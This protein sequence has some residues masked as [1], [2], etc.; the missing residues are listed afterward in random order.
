MP[1]PPTAELESLLADD[2]WI[3]RLARR[4]TADPSTA[5][6]LAQD[7][8]LAVLSGRAP[9]VAGTERPWLGRVLRN[10]WKDL[11]R[12]RGRRERRERSAAREEATPPADELVLELEL[13]ERLARALRELEE[14]YRRALVLRFLRDE[15]LA[16]IAKQEHVAV[17][18]IH[19][20]IERGLARL[21]ARLDDEHGGHRAAWAATLITLAPEASAGG[22]PFEVMALATVVKI[23]AAV[24]VLGTGAAWWW[25]RQGREVVRVSEAVVA[26]QAAAEAEHEDLRAL[27]PAPAAR[28]ALAPQV[29]SVPTPIVAGDEA[30]MISGRVLDPHG[31]GVSGALLGWRKPRD[32]DEPAVSAAD[33]AFELAG[34]TLEANGNVVVRSPEL[35]TL[36][37]GQLFGNWTLVAAPRAAFGGTVVDDSGAPIAGAELEF[38][39]K[40]TLF[41]AVGMHALGLEDERWSTTSDALGRFE[42]RDV[43]GGENV[44]LRAR[45]RGFVPVEVPLPEG[46]DPALLVT[47]QRKQATVELG[48]IVLDPAG[49]PVPGASVSAGKEIVTTG[50]DGRFTLL[51]DGGN[52]RSVQDE[53]GT[54]HEE[55]AERAQVIAL[56]AGYR[57]DQEALRERDL[58]LPFVLQL[59]A[60]LSITGFALDPEG[61]PLSGIVVWLQDPTRF[62]RER[63]TAGGAEFDR[64]LTVEDLVCARAEPAALTVPDGSF[65]IACLMDR[66]YSVLALDP[67]TCSRS[68][69]WSI[70]AGTQDVELVFTPEPTERVAGRIVSARGKPRAGLEVTPRRTRSW[71]AG[72]EAPELSGARIRVE[73]DAEGRFEFAQLATTG[74]A[75]QIAAQP[76]SMRVLELDGFTDLAR[77]E[78]VEPELCELQ[79]ELAGDPHSAT[80][81]EVLDGSG[82]ELELHEVHGG[83]NSFAYSLETE[84][85]LVEG[86]SRLLFVQETAS[87]LVLRKAGQEVLRVPLQLEPGRRVVKRL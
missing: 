82:T 86:R 42:L 54:W 87:E 24:L 33:G 17:S 13:R 60:P 32:G 40:E 27:A 20:R 50:A 30:A 6:D 51:W 47:L 8:W 1:V 74:T 65:E 10:T 84:V 73:T 57:P 23:A 34:H 85:Q 53:S 63:H 66:S 67:R 46:G 83:E 64:D 80:T 38:R 4:L 21:R 59:G 16:A 81:L 29:P 48:G 61:Q 5:E 9:R 41:R 37:F 18:T 71:A 77:L 56:K 45:A 31:R 58:A 55:G 11:L 78:I 2:R 70:A 44:A 26:A 15:S 19:E 52:G 14:P 22:G 43:T 25:S 72:A 62:G 39:L 76:F 35:V 28:E 69:P 49:A 75:L 7:T 79:V 3:R 68:G 12:G 36:V